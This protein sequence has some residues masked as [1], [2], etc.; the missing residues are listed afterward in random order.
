MTD[1]YSEIPV[2]PVAGEFLDMSFYYVFTMI[3]PYAL[4]TDKT[5]VFKG[6]LI[7]DIGSSGHS[8]QKASRKGKYPRNDF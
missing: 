3:S 8:L 1:I 7:E 5:G 6:L 2:P 4:S